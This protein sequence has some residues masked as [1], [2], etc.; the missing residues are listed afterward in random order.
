MRVI[1]KTEHIDSGKIYIGKSKKSEVAFKSYYGSGT[2]LRSAI[3]KYGKDAFTKTIIEQCDTDKQLNEREKYWINEFN[4][5]TPYG[6]NIHEG[7]LGGDSFHHLNKAQKKKIFEKRLNNNPDMYIKINETKIKNG[8]NKHSPEALVNVSKANKL[9][10]EDLNWRKKQSDYQLAN[11]STE[12]IYK[13]KLTTTDE[14]VE[15]KN[16][17]EV[18]DYVDNYNKTMNKKYRE[19]SNYWKL[20]YEFK[21]NDMIMVDKRRAN[22]E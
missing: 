5:I 15:L 22:Y 7:G 9:R 18:K 3:N 20:L 4:S 16:I 8:T 17:R 6:Y 14:I 12:K 11:S 10:S 1:Y 19:R 2:I 21:T 13:I